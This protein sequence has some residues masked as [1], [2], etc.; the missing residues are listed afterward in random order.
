MKQA[1]WVLVTGTSSGVGEA[2]VKLLSE[3]GYRV[4][5]TVR[6][7]TDARVVKEIFPDRI[8]P[9]HLELQDQETILAAMEKVEEMTG[10]DG[11]FGLVNCAGNLYCGPLEA[12]PRELW[13]AQYDVNLFGPMALTSAMIPLLRKTEG[14]IV[15]IGAVGGGIALPFYGAIASSKMAFEAVSDCLRRELHPWGIHVSIIEPGGINTPANRKMR[16]T[17]EKTLESMEPQVRAWYGPSMEAFSKWAYDMH[18]KNLQPEQVAKAVFKAMSAKRPRARY[19][20]GLD[21]LG[22]MLASRF[23]PDRLYDAVILK[24]SRLPL[25]FRAWS[26]R[27]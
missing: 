20:L 8:V 12:Y 24:V 14:R 18:T 23:L 17:V 22:V 19:R 13:F 3:K 11:L 27:R 25:R 15:N 2:T 21:S 9:L 5:A 26:D 4:L 6:S 16:E 7:D 1:Q 10:E